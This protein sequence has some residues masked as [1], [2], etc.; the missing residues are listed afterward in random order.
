MTT[1]L[2]SRAEKTESERDQWEQRARKLA[3]RLMQDNTS[4]DYGHEFPMG[5]ETPIDAEEPT[6]EESIQRWLE[7]AAA[8]PQKGGE[9]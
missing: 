4:L 9:A 3:E 5:F 6:D 8:E 1:K 7:W 2:K